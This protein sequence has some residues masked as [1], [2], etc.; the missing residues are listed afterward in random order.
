M[1]DLIVSVPDHC[2]FFSF[3]VDIKSLSPRGCLYK[4]IENVYKFRFRR[5]HFE[6]CNKWKSDK[7]FLLTSTFVPKGLSAPCPGAVYMYKSIKIYTRTM[8]QVSVYRTTGP[9]VGDFYDD[10]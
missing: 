9:L 1:W 3:S 7:D 4:I 6:T 2:L 10:F 8:C 5:D